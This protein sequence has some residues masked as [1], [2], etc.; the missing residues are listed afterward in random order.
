MYTEYTSKTK[1]E[2]WQYAI[3]NI[4]MHLKSPLHTR[5]HTFTH[6]C[7]ELPSFWRHRMVPQPLAG[8]CQD[9]RH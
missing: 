7:W 6:Q 2:A 9:H 4:A 8:M 3:S 5:M 1:Q